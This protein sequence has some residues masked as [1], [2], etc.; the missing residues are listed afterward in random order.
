MRSLGLIAALF[1]LVT[2]S[3]WAGP[4]V[5]SIWGEEAGVGQM[6]SSWFGS[7]GLI[8]TP[9]AAA[10]PPGS[11]TIAAHWVDSQPDDTTVVTVNF[12]LV[13]DLEVGGTWMQ[14]G[15][16]E[17]E[18]TANIKYRLDVGKWLGVPDMPE[19]AVGVWDLPNQ[20]NRAWYVVLSK[21]VPVDPTQ[22]TGAQIQLHLGWGQ[23]KVNGG[24]LDGVFGGVE[25]SAFKFGLL[26]A[27]YD[28]DKFNAAF[29]YNLTK[30]LSL[31]VGLVDERLGA[32]AS[33]RTKF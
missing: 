6:T 30:E 22:V 9:T 21:S 16:D 25:F 11:A 24:M 19:M 33:Y 28:G 18:V 10:L 15:D 13:K 14:W 20:V 17:S 27:E 29:R 1:G 12:G 23:S 3:A 5:V 8:A 26:Q 31:D 2:L 7:T 4:S 32:G